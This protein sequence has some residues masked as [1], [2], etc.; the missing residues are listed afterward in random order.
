MW[1]FGDSR[2]IIGTARYPSPDILAKC[3]EVAN[4]EVVTV[5]LR[6]ECNGEGFWNI[7]RDLPVKVLPNT[8]GCRSATEAVTLAEMARELFNTNWIKVEV[9]GD[10]YTLQPHPLE[11][12]KA[13]EELVKRGFTV[14]PYCTDDL[15]IAEKLVDCGCAALMPLGAAIGSGRGLDNIQGLKTLRH[16]FPETTLIIDAGIGAPS[17]ACMAMELGYDGVLLNTAIAIADDPVLMARAFARAVLGGRE[18][19][20]AGLMPKRNFATPSTPVLGTPFIS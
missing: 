2:L 13:C 6:R 1:I 9:T 20:E 10:E 3:I 5:S 15:V 12:I 19:R 17:H 4:V 8:A 16:R 11:L 18:G 7:I 14:F